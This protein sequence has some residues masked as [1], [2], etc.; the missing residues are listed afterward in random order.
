MIYDTSV[1][2]NISNL[3]NKTPRPGGYDIRDPRNGF[4]SFSPFDDL[5]GRRYSF[6]VTR[7]F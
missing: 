6:N 5:N 4:G 1:S 7:E 2:F 3:L